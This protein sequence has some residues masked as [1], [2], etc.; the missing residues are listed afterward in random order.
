MGLPHCPPR[1]RRWPLLI[2]EKE[3]NSS[4]SVQCGSGLCVSAVSKH[5]ACSMACGMSCSCTREADACEKASFVSPQP[6][7]L[8]TWAAVPLNAAVSWSVPLHSPGK[9][10]SWASLS[11]PCSLTAIWHHPSCQVY[12]VFSQTDPFIPEMNK[13]PKGFCFC[14]IYWYFPW[15]ALKMRH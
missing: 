5:H 8:W 10:A 1:P 11:G 2:S 6:L 7:S 4:W 13:D 14:F 3:D 12:A 15:L 9:V